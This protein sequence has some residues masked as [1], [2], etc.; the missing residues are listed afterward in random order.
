MS[1]DKF[2]Q[3]V[4]EGLS[5]SPKMLPSKYFY[6][7]RGDELFVEIMNM[8][9][10]YLSRAEHDILRT[11]SSQIVKA[12]K[13]DHDTSFEIVELGAGNGTKTYELLRVLIAEK[14]KFVY[15]PVDISQHAVDQLESALLREMPTLDL[16]PR[17][18][19]YFE[20][21]SELKETTHPKVVLFLGSNIGNMSDEIASKFIY[22][23]GSNLHP[24]DYLL[25]GVDLI[26][27]K[28]VV[29]PAYNDSQGITREFNLNLLTRINRELGGNF[30]VEAF[31]HAPEYAESEGVAKSYLKSLIDQ[32]VQIEGCSSAF[33]FT[34]G[35]KIHTEISRK[36]NDQVLNRILADTNFTIDQS[37]V[38][39]KGLFAD[40]LLKRN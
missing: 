15:V 30:Q 22:D 38:D 14:Y 13:Q 27:S 11:Q 35:E 26:K 7:K 23:L 25:L 16:H 17:Q 6:D 21:L 12:L 9:E 28:D 8:P 3:D 10:Y 20:I 37:F 40:Y 24:G 34:E 19:D 2:L 31:D 18:G 33:K 4:K 39:S 1:K 36:Y 5:R 29:L 32:T